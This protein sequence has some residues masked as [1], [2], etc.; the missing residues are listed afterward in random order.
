MGFINNDAVELINW[1]GFGAVEN[2][3]HHRLHG[4]NLHAG[5]GFGHL[6]PQFGNIVNLIQGLILLHLHFFEGIGCLVA[7]GGAVYQKEDA[8]EAF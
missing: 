7:Q 1:R 6:P 2:P 5:G 3:F 4:G 8:F